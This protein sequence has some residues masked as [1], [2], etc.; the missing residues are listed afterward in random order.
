ML[1][2]L[3]HKDEHGNLRVDEVKCEHLHEGY[4]LTLYE[5]K[6]ICEALNKLKDYEDSWLDP[7]AVENIKKDLMNREWDALCRDDDER[8]QI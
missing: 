8:K 1:K 2:R 5:A 3:T 6:K 4:V 7:E